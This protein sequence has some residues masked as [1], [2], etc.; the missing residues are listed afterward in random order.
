MIKVS[1]LVTTLNAADI[2]PDCLTVLKDFNEIIVIDS[3]SQDG[4]QDI[5][6]NFGAKFVNYEWDKKYPKKRQWCLDNIDIKNDFVFF[7]DADEVLTSDLIEEIKS[8]D[9]NTAGYFVKGNYIWRNKILKYGLKN[10]KLVLL[11]R[12]KIEFPV[13]DDLDI[14]GM[15]EIEGHYQPVLKKAYQSEVIGQLKSCLYHDA[16][17]NQAQWE[18]RHKRY[19]AWEAG[20]IKRQAYPKDPSALRELIK[21]TFRRLPARGFIAFCHSYILKLGFLDGI[22]GYQFA[23]SRWRYYQMVSA[24]LSANKDVA[25]FCEDHKEHSALQK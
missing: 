13:I 14:E 2:L 12:H 5:A 23:R 6:Q 11:N 9:L 25:L 22:A 7:V 1:V 19:A 15:G 16:Y 18:S 3:N 21:S 17:D 4:T 20:M 8:L 10:N 24:A